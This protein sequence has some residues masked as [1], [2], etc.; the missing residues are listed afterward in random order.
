[1]IEALFIGVSIVIMV[2]YVIQIRRDGRSLFRPHS[3]GEPREK[4]SLKQ[5]LIVGLIGF[6][7]IVTAMILLIMYNG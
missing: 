3:L 2:I 7:A 1:M 5:E 6:I 4:K